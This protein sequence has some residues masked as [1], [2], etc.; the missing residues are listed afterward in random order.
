MNKENKKRMRIME[1]L[2]LPEL[3]ARF[4][5]DVGLPLRI[6]RP[7]DGEADRSAG[8]VDG[9]ERLVGTRLVLRPATLPT[10]PLAIGVLEPEPPP[11]AIGSLERLAVGHRCTPFRGG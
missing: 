4:H 7:L 10:S 1:E 3:Q 6:E 2:R 11:V 5:T 8:E 9:L